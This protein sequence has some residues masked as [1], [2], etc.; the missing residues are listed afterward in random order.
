M[1]RRRKKK[2]NIRVEKDKSMR[3]EG[4]ETEGNKG[5]KKWVRTKEDKDKIE[6]NI[7]REKEEISR[8][9]RRRT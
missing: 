8:E 9:R 1:R 2:K 4:G 6:E 7:M 3:I 5:G